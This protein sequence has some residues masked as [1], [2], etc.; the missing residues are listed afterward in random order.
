MLPSTAQPDE[1]FKKIQILHTYRLHLFIHVE[2]E[3]KICSSSSRQSYN[4]K[5]SLNIPSPALFTCLHTNAQVL[6][7]Q[8]QLP[9]HHLKRSD[10]WIYTQAYT[11]SSHHFPHQ[12]TDEKWWQ[13]PS[14]RESWTS[15]WITG[16]NIIITII[17]C[18]CIYVCI[19]PIYSPT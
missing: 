18:I 19:Y 3:N 16:I 6:T 13:T 4:L 15:N 9:N 1:L 10:S 17:V 8:V 12:Y 11:T 7:S 2:E 5:Q 14:K